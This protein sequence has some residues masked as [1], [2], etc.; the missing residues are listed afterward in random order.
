MD[1]NTW[2]L[3]RFPGP[4][5]IGLGVVT[6]LVACGDSA[7]DGDGATVRPTP[8][9][10]AGYPTAT[11][12]IL[13]S[14]ESAD[15]LKGITAF[16]ARLAKDWPTPQGLT[17]HTATP[18][19]TPVDKSSWT[20]IKPGE[21][22]PRATTEA[23][24]LDDLKRRIFAFISRSWAEDQAVTSDG[25]ALIIHGVPVGDIEMEP[26]DGSGFPD[27]F[28]QEVRILSVLNGRAPGDTVRVVQIAFDDAVGEGN[29]ESDEATLGTGENHGNHGPVGQCP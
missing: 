1:V 22:D 26:A 24:E 10:A 23:G 11:I 13:D 29:S 16:N 3:K 18:S 19:P 5:L 4:L 14:W 7:G 6:A 21:C 25:A 27:R 12:E 2:M 20:I 15:D 28:Y 8:R 9:F 17:N